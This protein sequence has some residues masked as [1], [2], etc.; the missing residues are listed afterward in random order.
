MGR[1]E[2][3]IGGMI[4]GV[5]L[6]A[7]TYALAAWTDTYARPAVVYSES[8]ELDRTTYRDKTGAFWTTKWNADARVGQRVT[9]VMS[10]NGTDDDVDDD[11]V[12]KVRAAK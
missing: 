4:L 3:L 8:L 6:F 11:I 1:R 12:I 2:T 7:L 5:V 9:L 10:C